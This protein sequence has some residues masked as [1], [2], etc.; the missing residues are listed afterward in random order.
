MQKYVRNRQLT[1]TADGT[2]NQTAWCTCKYGGMV[3]LEGTFVGTVTP[4]RR[5]VDGNAVDV[6]DSAGNVTAFTLPGTYP[7]NAEFVAGDYRLK[8]KSGNYTSG[9]I[10]ILI[11]GR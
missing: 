9:S 3:T 8:V 7:L 4:Q 11:E 2:N 5:G 6:T 10:G 1:V